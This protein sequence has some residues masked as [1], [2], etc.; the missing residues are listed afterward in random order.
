MALSEKLKKW[1][2]AEEVNLTV[3][4][5]DAGRRFSNDNCTGIAAEMAYYFLFALFP[6]MLFLLTVLAYLPVENLTDVIMNALKNM[7]PGDAFNLIKSNVDAIVGNRKGGILSIS[8]VLALWT[9]SSAIIAVMEGL[10]TAYSVKE[11]RP[12]WKKRLLAILLVIGFALFIG[13]SGVLLIFGPK[14]GEAVAGLFG[15][16]ELFQMAWNILRWVVILILVSLAFAATYYFAPNTKQ[17]WR[18]LSV[19]SITAVVG[20]LAVSMAFSFYVD[21]FGSYNKTYGTIGAVIVLLTWMYASGLVILLGGE[22]NSSLEQRVT[23][24]RDVKSH[25]RK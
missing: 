19:G 1:L 20:W 18:W 2:G 25:S 4:A 23:R 24:I 22:F 10:N 7:V 9:S 8:I 5:K 15:L 16:G 17:N 13:F 3:V 14:I 12:F 11:T 21:N 6:F